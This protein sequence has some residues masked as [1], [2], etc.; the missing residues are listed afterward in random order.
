M[1]V[2]LNTPEDIEDVISMLWQDMIDGEIRTLTYSMK[3][4]RGVDYEIVDDGDTLA[5]FVN[6]CILSP[7]THYDNAFVKSNTNN[8]IM[9]FEHHGATSGTVALCPATDEDAYLD[10]LV[11]INITTPD[12]RYLTLDVWADE[13]A[14]RQIARDLENGELEL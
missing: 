10:K 12:G 4:R 7:I 1:K 3:T 9:T 8:V 13:W 14:D 6:G 5:P 2:N 11:D